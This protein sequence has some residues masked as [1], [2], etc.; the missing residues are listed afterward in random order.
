MRRQAFL[1]VVAAI[2]AAIALTILLTAGDSPPEGKVRAVIT[3]RVDNADADRQADNAMRV[4]PVAVK[5]AEASDVGAHAGSRDETPAGASEAD[6]D[7]AQRQQDDLAASDQF[8][9]LAPSAAASFPGCRTRIVANRSSRRGVAPRL[10]V[11]HI[12]VSPNRP[13]WS[14]VDGITA[15]FNRPSTQASSHFVVDAEGHCNYI[16]PINEKSWTEAAGNPVS[17]SWEIINTGREGRLLD[18]AGYKALGEQ[19]AR[20]GRLLSIPLRKGKVSGCR[21]ARSGI[22]MHKDFGQCGGGHVDITPYALEPVIA[23]AQRAAGGGITAADRDTCRKI[24]AWRNA[25]RPKGG[26]WER[27]TVARKRELA[28]RGVTCGPHGPTR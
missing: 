17:V 28:K 13:G 10:L 16:V 9:I 18:A 8:P 25:G 21:V 5:A 1:G 7:A 19:M 3:T 6:L 20:V 4:P 26:Q 27:N 14:D 22:V 15:Y 23:A 11:A 2:L 24:N 12:T